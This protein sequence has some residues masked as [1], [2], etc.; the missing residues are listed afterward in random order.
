MPDAL[1]S[2]FPGLGLAPPMAPITVEDG[3]LGKKFRHIQLKCTNRIN[4]EFCNIQSI[5]FSKTAKTLEQHSLNSPSSSV[6]PPHFIFYSKVDQSQVSLFAT[7][8][9]FSSTALL[10]I[11]YPASNLYFPHMLTMHSG[12]STDAVYASTLVFINKLDSKISD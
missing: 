5:G 6:A 12:D 2:P 10:C 3:E 11:F 4:S 1:P 9:T 8:I 7:K